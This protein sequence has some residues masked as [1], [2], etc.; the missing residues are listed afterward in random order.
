M[1][2]A[3]DIVLL[4]AGRATRMRGADKMLQE[5][6]VMLGTEPL[7]RAMARRCAR[8]GP[9]RVVIARDQDARR[10]AVADLDVEIVDIPPGGGMAASIVAGVQGRDGPMIVV[11][12]DMP[13]VTANDI[14]RLAGLSR[15]APQA[16]LRAAAAD[17]TPG[18]PVLFPADLRPALEGLT[19]DAGARA[20]LQAHEA[21]VHLV[22]L[23]GERAL[24]DLDTPEDW[25]RWRKA[26]R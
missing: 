1:E 10:A 14:Y 24:T 13:D 2:D 22:P 3:I 8:V 21:R 5:V 15:Q 19:G 20:I 7:I 23:D 25:A 9:T 17:G 4:A 18:H 6:P 12:A 16:I 26:Q 11:L